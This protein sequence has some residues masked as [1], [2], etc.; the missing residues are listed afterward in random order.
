M[1]QTV[2]RSKTRYEKI[3]DRLAERHSDL[4]SHWYANRFFC[5]FPQGWRE[6]VVKTSASWYRV[7]QETIEKL[8]A[9]IEKLEAQTD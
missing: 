4:L 7:N 2:K 8:E 5:K 3:A 9:K 6:L 1:Q